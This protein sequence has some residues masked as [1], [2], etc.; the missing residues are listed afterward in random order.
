MASNL[1]QNGRGVFGFSIQKDFDVELNFSRNRSVTT[2]QSLLVIVRV[3]AGN[4]G[5]TQTLNRNFGGD[6]FNLILLELLIQ[7]L[8]ME[9]PSNGARCI[10]H[11]IDHHLSFMQTSF[12]ILLCNQVTTS[13]YNLILGNIYCDHHGM[14][15]IRGN[16]N[17]SCKLKFKEQSILDRNPRQVS[18]HLE[19]LL[20]AKTSNALVSFCNWRN[21]DSILSSIHKKY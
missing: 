3:K 10:Q 15:H 11:F 13:I 19:F 4:F 9:R 18:F 14:M 1:S 16:R 12:E 8:M 21:F 7:S 5:V 2:L 6:Q 20:K 17:Y